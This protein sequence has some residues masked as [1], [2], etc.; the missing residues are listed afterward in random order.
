M[1]NHAPEHGV[2]YKSFLVISTDFLF[3]YDCK[4]YL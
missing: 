3:V 2:E 1:E 4:H